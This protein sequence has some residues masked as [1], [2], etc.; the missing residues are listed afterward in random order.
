M[1]KA[2][3]FFIIQHETMLCNSRREIRF[4]R[5]CELRGQWVLGKWAT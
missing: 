3:L 2:F 1:I 5:V 4:A